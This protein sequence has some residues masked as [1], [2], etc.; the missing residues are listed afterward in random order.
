MR[1]FLLPGVWA[2]ALAAPF[3]APALAAPV[4]TPTIISVR[5]H[6]ATAFTQGLLLLNDRLY[7]STGLYGS[8]SVRRVHPLTGQ[9]EQTA[10]LEASLFGEGLAVGPNVMGQSGQHLIQLTWKEHVA[11]VWDPATL[12]E[13]KRIAYTGEGWG[14]C[15]DGTR[16][17]MSDGSATLTF[18]DAST[19]AVTGTLAVTNDGQPQYYLNELECGGALAPG[20]LYANVWQTGYIVK[21]DPHNGNVTAELDLR[22]LLTPAEAANAD[23]LNGIAALSPD[24]LL[25][26]GKLWPKMFEISLGAAID[27]GAR[28]DSGP[29]PGD[30]KTPTPTDRDPADS[31]RASATWRG[32]PG[33]TQTGLAPLWCW[34]VLMGG[35]ELARRLPQSVATLCRLVG[36]RA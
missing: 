3:S 10:V 36:Q 32:Q 24:R 11:V 22:G 2:L 4:R 6:D 31:A 18:R 1:I 8:S 29:S 23:V 15:Y 25:V 12:T 30:S 7:E 26:T 14:L 28:G 13:V 21:I 16:L 17:V 27:D 5:P 9:V 34:L 35:P 33:C 19:F 20:E